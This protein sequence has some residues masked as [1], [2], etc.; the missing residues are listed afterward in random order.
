M[1][2]SFFYGA[3]EAVSR[4]ELN[5]CSTVEGRW[6]LWFIL[7]ELY[8]PGSCVRTTV[9]DEEEGLFLPLLRA[10]GRTGLAELQ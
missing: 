9:A 10:G 4:N 6:F 2:V 7:M 1:F 3:K 8:L 5:S